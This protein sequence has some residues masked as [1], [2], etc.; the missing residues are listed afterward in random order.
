MRSVGLHRP[1]VDVPRAWCGPVALA[2]ITGRPLS[3][4]PLLGRRGGMSSFDVQMA[5]RVN[6]YRVVSCSTFARGERLPL[7]RYLASRPPARG[8]LGVPGHWLAFDGL[9]VLDTYLPVATWVYD[10]PAAR[11]KV[12]RV[13]RVVPAPGSIEEWIHADLERAASARRGRP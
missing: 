7:H 9:L 12:K 4:F 2:A 13:L 8:I 11:R 10:H 1:V 6:G 5:L 3:A